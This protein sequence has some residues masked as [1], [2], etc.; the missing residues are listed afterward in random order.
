MENKTEIHYK[1][2]DDG[3]IVVGKIVPSDWARRLSKKTG[4]SRQ[5]IYVLA[6][7]LGRIPTE[8]EVNNQRPGR[9]PKFK[10]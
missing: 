1:M 6:N 4:K 3:S 7:K 10:R 8:E 9:P 2:G 5:A